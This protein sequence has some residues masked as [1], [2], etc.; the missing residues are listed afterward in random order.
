MSGN[1]KF[2]RAQ[3]NP[4]NS[5]LYPH[6]RFNFT[7]FDT[8]LALCLVWHGVKQPLE[9]RDL[10]ESIEI[11]WDGGFRLVGPMFEVKTEH[12]EIGHRSIEGYPFDAIRKVLEK[13]QSTERRM[14]DIF[15][16]PD[17]VPL[18]PEL[19]EKLV[20]EGMERAV[21]EEGLKHGATYSP[22]RDSL[23]YPPSSSDGEDAWLS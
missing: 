9:I 6:N 16:R 23:L 13:A 14:V 7:A 21:L 4:Q 8:N 17:G 1:E 3:A 19:V 20:S 10:D 22:S 12:A 15:M 2:P 18:T 11:L 5:Q